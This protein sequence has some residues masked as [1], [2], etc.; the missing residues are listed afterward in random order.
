MSEHMKDIQD[1]CELNSMVKHMN[2]NPGHEFDFDSASVLWKTCNVTEQKIVETACISSLPNCN[3]SGGEIPVD[4][5]LSSLIMRLTSI[6]CL[7]SG[8]DYGNS[9]SHSALLPL[10]PASHLTPPIQPALTQ[11][12]Q[13]ISHPSPTMSQPES[14][15][16]P[17]ASQPHTASQ[18]VPLMSPAASHP[19]PPASQPMPSTSQ[20]HVT[21]PSTAFSSSLPA[22]SS[23]ID[24]FSS[25]PPDSPIAGRTRSAYM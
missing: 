14:L 4:P 23:V 2:A 17:S 24:R 22:R 25:R 15:L 12:T 19:R 1:R 20:P 3:T 6:P 13:S 18:P 8:T 21:H 10:P 11:P 16:T 7:A 5:I 9:L